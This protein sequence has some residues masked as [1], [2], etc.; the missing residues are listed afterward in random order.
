MRSRSSR[1]RA[2]RLRP[3]RANVG[4]LTAVELSSRRA[5]V[6]RLLA[7]GAISLPEIPLAPERLFFTEAL[8]QIPTT[9][10]F[11]N[12]V[13]VDRLLGAQSA[14]ALTAWVAGR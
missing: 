3:R 12:G 13:L 11:R 2:A 4:V 7:D 10:L 5:D 1:P 9:L 6:D 14:D 8:N